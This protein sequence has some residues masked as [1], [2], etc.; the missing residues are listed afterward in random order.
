M[1]D[2]TL[3]DV[4]LNIDRLDMTFLRRSLSKHSTGLSLLP[5]P[6][7]MEDVGL[8]HEDHLQRVI[9][10]WRATYTHLEPDLGE[11]FT[12][13]DHTALRMAD[14]IRLVTQLE[15]SSLRNVVRMLLTLGADE[16]LANKVKIVLNRVGAD[17]SDGAIT[18]RKAEETIGK[19]IFYQIPNDA[20]AMMGARN[21]G[22]P[23]L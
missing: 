14:T 22:V 17:M 21:A 16:G 20:K 7:Q 6:G 23:L 4:A 18:V 8:I 2:Y 5:H 19:P 9:G 10:L 3:A 15:L 1:P 12:A 11:R 13:T